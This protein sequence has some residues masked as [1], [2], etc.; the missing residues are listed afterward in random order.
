VKTRKN[1]NTVK[2]QKIARKKMHKEVKRGK[3]RDK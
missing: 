3:E 2:A 1:Y